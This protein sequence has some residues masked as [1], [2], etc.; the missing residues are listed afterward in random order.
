MTAWGL[1]SLSADAEL[2]ASELVAN[3]AEHGGG[4]L[5][6]LTISR[7]TDP[8]GQQG[9][10]CQVTDTGPGT[11]TVQ[12][13]REGSERG[14]GLQIVSA[15]ATKSGVSR[16]AQGKTAWFTLT[17]WPEVTASARHVDFEPEPGD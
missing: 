8:S 11:P 1:D 6:G 2:L 9:I 4:E 10:L 7:H 13:F 3:S 15:L 17:A 5:I 12:P 16:T 14:R